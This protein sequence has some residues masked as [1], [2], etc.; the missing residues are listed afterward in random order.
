VTHAGASRISK[1]LA[2]SLYVAKALGGTHRF[3]P[4]ATVVR[5]VGVRDASSGPPEHAPV[6]AQ[7]GVLLLEAEERRVV[8]REAVDHLKKSNSS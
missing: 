7:H 8:A 3:L 4:D 1:T 6:T 5:S 2:P